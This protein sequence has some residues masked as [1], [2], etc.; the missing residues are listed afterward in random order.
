MM[1]RFCAAIAFPLAILTFTFADK[2]VLILFGEEYL[3]GQAA[4][5]L[6]ILAPGFLF[7][8]VSGPVGPLLINSREK[9]LRFIPPALAITVANVVLNFV[10]IPKYS[11]RGAAM[12]TTF[13]AFLEMAVKVRLVNELFEKKPISWTTFWR[14]AACS[15]PMLLSLYLTRGW[16]FILSASVSTCLYALCIALVALRGGRSTA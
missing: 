5:A 2:I 15:L 11:F 16:F 6:R 13:C 12:S 1:A 10:L 4:A 3:D 14:P 9:I 8:V 7:L